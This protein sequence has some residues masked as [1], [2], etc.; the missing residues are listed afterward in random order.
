MNYA[1]TMALAQLW[2]VWAISLAAFIAACILTSHAD[3]IM[4][5]LLL[6]LLCGV[7]MVLSQEVFMKAIEAS[8]SARRRAA[9]Q[10]ETFAK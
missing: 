6:G 5:R 10:A 8:K 1:D 9:E 4:P 2:T 7:L 3:W